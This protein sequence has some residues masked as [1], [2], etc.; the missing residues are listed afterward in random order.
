MRK[1]LRKC[2]VTVR[3]LITNKLK[4]YAAANKDMGLRFGHRQYKALN[5]RPENSHQPTHVPEKVMRR[6]KSARQL[7]RCVSVHDPGSR[8]ASSMSTQRERHKKRANRSQTFA[9][10]EGLP[11]R[12]HLAFRL[13]DRSEILKLSLASILAQQVDSTVEGRS[14]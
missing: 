12:T 1:P 4:S 5:N 11:A 3:A 6:F 7:Q 14:K 10:W 8:H 9:T 13:H 2:G